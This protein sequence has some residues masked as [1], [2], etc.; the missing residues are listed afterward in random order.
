M[1]SLFDP[2]TLRG[3]TARNRIWLAPMCQY[4]VDRA[5]GVPGSWHLVHLGARATGGFGLVMTEATAVSPAGRITPRDVGIWNDEQALAWQRIVEF[6]VAQG[7]SPAVQLAHAGRKASTAAPWNGGGYLP[8]HEG[9]WLPA[10]PSPLAYQGLAVPKELTSAD[11][12]RLV[13]SFADAA[14]RAIDAGF[15]VV[16]LHAAHGYLLHE[17][18]SPLSNNRKDGYG[19][20]F[21]NRVRLTLEVVDAIRGVLPDQTPLLVRLSAT[22]WVDGGWS[23][24]DTVRLSSLL[25]EHGVDLVDLSSGGND[26]RQ[27][28]PVQPGYQVPFARAVRRE[29]RLPTA[30]V[31]LITEP[32]QAQA[33]LDEESADVVLLARAALRESAW[34]LRAAAELGVPPAEVPYPVQYH[35]A[36]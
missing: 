15:A 17:F 23:L 6:V 1:P 27:H 10:G 30:A 25:A 7:A 34:P 36:R 8:P 32:K 33:I 3:V 9:G 4:S 14:R 11:I 19:G 16:E 28:I 12:E 24:D 13:A 35:R 21:D 2:V 18:L 31:G 26:R 22:D 20:C 29:A 5:D